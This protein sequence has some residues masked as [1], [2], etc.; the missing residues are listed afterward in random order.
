MANERQILHRALLTRYLAVQAA[1]DPATI[2][3][4]TYGG[5]LNLQKMIKTQRERLRTAFIGGV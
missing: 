5:S 4:S 1:G 3:S 2:S